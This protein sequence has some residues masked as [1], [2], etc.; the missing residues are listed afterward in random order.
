M[1]RVGW[2][3]TRGNNSRI[4]DEIKP[5]FL[6]RLASKYPW[7]SSV[8]VPWKMHD[9]ITWL[10]LSRFR[11]KKKK[12]YNPLSLIRFRLERFD[13]RSFRSAHNS[14]LDDFSP[15][16]THI[17]T[18]YFSLWR[19]F[20]GFDLSWRAGVSLSGQRFSFRRR[21]EEKKINANPREQGEGKKRRKIRADARSK[22]KGK[23]EL[24]HARHPNVTRYIRNERE[25][26]YE[27][28]DH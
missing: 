7:L 9:R 11:S 15:P 6:A 21:K 23:T 20:P 12:R 5:F 18:I 24:R 4:G 3:T 26:E 16:D 10:F 14:R 22:S 28:W 13:S 17:S 19:W 25:N 27:C 1:C 8:K 2:A